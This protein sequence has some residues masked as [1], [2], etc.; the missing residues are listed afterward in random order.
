MNHAE[1]IERIYEHL[2]NDHVEKAVMACL[3]IARNTQDHL[4]AAIFL[5]ELYPDEQLFSKIFH[6]D[7]SKLNKEAHAFL[8]KTSL[9]TEFA[10]LNWPTSIV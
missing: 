9:E 8:W 2:E 6:E 1:V 5:R 4:N 7:T 3:R 10:H